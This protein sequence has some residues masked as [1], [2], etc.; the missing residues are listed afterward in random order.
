[1]RGI[2]GALKPLHCQVG[3]NLR[4]DEVRVAH[5]FLHAVQVSASVEQMGGVTVP[6]FVRRQVLVQSGNRKVLFQAQLEVPGETGVPFFVLIVKT[7]P[8][9][10]GGWGSRRQ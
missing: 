4:R 1:M 6:Q 9:T 5:E 3:I 8:P 2:I 10:P 7:R